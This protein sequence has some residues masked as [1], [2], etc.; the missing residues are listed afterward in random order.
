MQC[1]V[2][3]EDYSG[4]S[5]TRLFLK[6]FDRHYCRGSLC[7]FRVENFIRKCEKNSSK[8]GKALSLLK[9]RLVCFDQ[10]RVVRVFVSSLNARSDDERRRISSSVRLD[11]RKWKLNIVSSK[12]F[13]SQTLWDNNSRMYH[14]WLLKVSMFQPPSLATSSDL[15]L[16][17]KCISKI[18][19]VLLKP[20]YRYPYYSPANWAF[21]NEE[22]ATKYFVKDYCLKYSINRKNCKKKNA[23]TF[24]SFWNL[25]QVFFEVF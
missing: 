16:P 17:V 15:Q 13:Y 10:V 18:D 9:R 5:S 2:A 25:F 8:V 11:E 4:E 22:N 23:S 12:D 6:V 3:N 1:S 19:S 20:K 21:E 7:S 14:I 24:L